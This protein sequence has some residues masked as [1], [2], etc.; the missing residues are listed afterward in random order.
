MT[1]YG[2][3]LPEQVWDSKPIPAR[4]FVSGLDKRFRYASRLGAQRFY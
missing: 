3:L 2:R 1:G 4:Y